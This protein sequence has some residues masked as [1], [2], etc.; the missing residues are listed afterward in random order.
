MSQN[1]I[2]LV[3]EKYTCELCEYTGNT[4]QGIKSHNTKK[5][6]GKNNEVEVNTLKSL[7]P[8][9]PNSDNLEKR[10]YIL[11]AIKTVNKTLECNK[12][13]PVKILEKT[14]SGETKVSNA[15]MTLELNLGMFEHMKSQFGNELK[16]IGKKL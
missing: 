8:K 11:N 2:A 16:N 15:T 6:K 13:P 3:V 10:S 7:N 4:L 9:L 12:R 5:H 1:A 14:T